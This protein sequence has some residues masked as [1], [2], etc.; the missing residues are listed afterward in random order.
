MTQNLEAVFQHDP[1][2]VSRNIAG[3]MIL[4]PIR[5]NVSDMA[6]V[7]T[8]NETG[9]MIWENLNGKNSLNEIIQLMVEAYQVSP[10]E[11]QQDI[12]DLINNLQDIDALEAVS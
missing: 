5:S 7:Y 9:A 4:V 3:E 8:L 1:N 12:S 6:F 10:E 2:I 11:A